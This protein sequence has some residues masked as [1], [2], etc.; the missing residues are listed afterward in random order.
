VDTNETFLVCLSGARPSNAEEYHVL[1]PRAPLGEA[2]FGR[3]EGDSVSLEVVK[4][5][6]MVYEVL[7]VE[8]T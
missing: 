1:S 2:L 5:F 8:N 7:K 4:G 3:R 6:K